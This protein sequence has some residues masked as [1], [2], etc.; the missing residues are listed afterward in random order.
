MKVEV[1]VK[2]KVFND[3]YFP[4]LTNN[5]RYLVLYGGAGSGKS[6][7]IA[8]RYILKL[9]NSNKCNLLAVRAVANTLRD[10]VFAELRKV[11]KS[12]NLVKLFK[13]NVSDMR[14][15]CVNGNEVLF[16]GLDDVERLKSITFVNG[17][18]T[19]VWIEEAS[20]VLEE[21]FKQLDVRLRGG[22]TLKQMTISF[23]PIDVNH[24]LKKR[25]FDR[26]EP[27]AT[28]LKTTYIDNRFLDEEYKELLESYKETD[29]YYYDVYCRGMWGVFGKTIFN[30]N[31]VNSQI[32]RNITPCKIGY[33]ILD[34]KKQYKWIE[35]E[36]GDIQIYREIE[37]GVPYVI[38]A[39]TAG[40]GSD[41]GTAQVL[42]N[43]NGELVATMRTQNDEDLYT[44]QLDALGRYYNN[45][46]IGVEANFSTYP[47]RK[48]QE[49]KYPKQYYREVEDRITQKLQMSYGFKTTSLTRPLIL[50]NLIAVMRE[51]IELVGNKETLFEMLSFVRNGKG[52]MEAQNGAH[53][54]L[55]MALAIA[56]Y[57]RPQQKYEKA[58]EVIK[59]HYNFEFERPKASPYG[60]GI[61]ITPF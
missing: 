40:D 56:H 27:K 55:I 24:W 52:R 14:I 3:I 37:S 8:Q 61:K 9:L 26:K 42:D 43:T 49:M 33:F 21:D 23:N 7:F 6:V 16:R 2:K 39:D 1:N 38:G 51:N 10:S 13:I 22:T 25:F 28:V 36:N 17:E 32:E 30:A 59:P 44:I 35:D 15:T 11:I 4:L 53:D 5:S 60:N 58:K 41:Y 57:I 46:L 45:A 19:D 29:P 20:E 12:W 48:L 50:S 31:E 47:I 18:L 34:E 54:D